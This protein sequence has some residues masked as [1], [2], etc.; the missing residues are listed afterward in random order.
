MYKGDQTVKFDF[1][2]NARQGCIWAGYFQRCEAEGDEI[3]T[4]KV[5]AGDS[6]DDS[7]SQAVKTV[8]IVKNSVDSSTVGG[9]A[10]KSVKMT[11]QKAHQMLGHSN[12]AATRKTA[13]L[14]GWT[15]SPGELKV[16][17]SCAKDKGKQK[18]VNKSSEAEKATKPFQRVFLDIKSIKPPKDKEDTPFVVKKNL[19]VIVDEYSG[20]GFAEW[21]QKK[22][23]MIEPT[24]KLFYQWQ[25]KG[26]EIDFVRCDNAGENV[27]LEKR[28]K[29][30]KWKM[31][32]EF[33]FTPR[34]T[35]RFN[36]LAELKIHLI[37]N[38]ARAM[39]IE[40]NVPRKYR[41]RC[42]VLANSCAMM[43]DWLVTVVINGVEKSR[44][45]HCFECL[46]KFAGN[47]RTWGEAGVVTIKSDNWPAVRNRAVTCFFA[48]YLNESNHDAYEMYE[49][50][51]NTIYRTRDI[52]WLE[53]MYFPKAK[54]PPVDISDNFTDILDLEDEVE[55]PISN[56]GSEVP[57]GRI[58]N[59][60]RNV[61][62]DEGESESESDSESDSENESED[63]DA[64]DDIADDPVEPP[65]V[66]SD[67]ETQVAENLT[68]TEDEPREPVIA[69]EPYRTRFGRAIKPAS[70]WNGNA[71][72]AFSALTYV[73]TLTPAE[74]KFHSAM[75]ELN[76]FGLLNTNA[77]CAEA[78]I[79]EASLVG[80]TGTAFE[81]IQDLKVMTYEEAMADPR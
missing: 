23:G 64:A 10:K 31:T 17:E 36:H 46:R 43:L 78:M 40:A 60:V 44:F 38:K 73:A 81:K 65:E 57:V 26:F 39:M 58:T 37:C 24:T 15:L 34:K 11:V 53:H 61:T 50:L 67:E 55:Q 49:P 18:N 7:V 59:G 25:K 8:K 1:R 2:I 72:Y 5:Q 27:R 66:E 6:A 70:A 41:Y 54:L 75:Q 77:P 30:A 3:S 71:Q 47:L 56:S 13:K 19:R 68:G 9:A 45:N 28:A 42:F 16:C 33:E 29:D 4:I 35:P 32:M 74:E 76:E 69:E 12:E 20:C 80:A 48:G 62:V 63:E 51:S 21:F 22:S 52:L 79:E 14:L